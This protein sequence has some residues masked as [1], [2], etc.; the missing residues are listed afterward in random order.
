MDVTGIIKKKGSDVVSLP[1]TATIA[2][3]VSLLWEKR[4]GAIVILDEDSLAGIA[5]ERDVVRYLAAAGSVNEPV[6]AIM[7]TTVTTC[8]PDD[9][10]KELATVMTNGRFRH[11]PVIE[12]GKVVGIVSIGDVVKAR[13]DDLEAERDH[14][15]RYVHSESAFAQRMN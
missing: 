12:G 15:E 2:E 6:T 5:S 11:L 13:L 8:S 1:S 9:E 3:L 7:T 14:L 10:V 4:I